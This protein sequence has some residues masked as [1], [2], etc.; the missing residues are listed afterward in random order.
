MSESETTI[1]VNSAKGRVT[2]PDWSVTILSLKR[3]AVQ[4]SLLI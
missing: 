4:T 2:T 1:P 3:M